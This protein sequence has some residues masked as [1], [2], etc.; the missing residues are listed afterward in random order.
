MSL[1]NVVTAGVCIKSHTRPVPLMMLSN[2]TIGLLVGWLLQPASGG[3]LFDLSTLRGQ[4]LRMMAMLAVG[5]GNYGNLPIIVMSSLCTDPTS[6]V[7]T[8][9]YWCRL[10]LCDTMQVGAG[11]QGWVR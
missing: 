8:L 5:V 7:G 10:R 1:D 2:V 11:V 6:A 4:Q 3:V 9:Q